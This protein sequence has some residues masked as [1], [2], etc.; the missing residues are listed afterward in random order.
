M[1]SSHPWAERYREN[2]T[3]W[4]LG[5]T[6][7]ELSRRIATGDNVLIPNPNAKRAL[8]PGCG[9]GWDALAFADAG[10]E[11]SALDLVSELDELL[12]PKLTAS[13]SKFI[14]GD[15]FSEETYLQLIA[16]G[17]FDLVFDHT[18]FCAI[19]LALREQFG[20]QMAKLIK[21]GGHLC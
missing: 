4:D 21:P 8:V 14:C 13:N 7:P 5:E 11:V 3:P 16:D 19:P 2:T 1:N 15:F 9:R 18:F 12:T 6:H 10:W 17:L 20:N